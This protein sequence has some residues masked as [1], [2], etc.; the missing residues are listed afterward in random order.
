MKRYAS[1]I[2]L[3]REHLDEYMRIHEAVWPEIYDRLTASNFRNF[4]IFIREFPSGEL[5]LFMY[6]EY[7]GTDHEADSRA[8]AD[9][10]K[11]QEW[12]KI[13]DPMQELLENR[14]PGEKWASMIEVCHKP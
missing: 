12:W 8:I 4:S 3:K 14:A 13:T 2:R 11:T 6:Y 9:D 7:D 10:P 5:Y 1:T